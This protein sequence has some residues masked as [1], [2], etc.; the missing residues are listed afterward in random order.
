MGRAVTR[1]PEEFQQP[2]GEHLTELRKRLLR[3][4][5]AFAVTTALSLTLSAK[6]LEFLLRPVATTFFYGPAEA[7]SA[8]LRVAVLIGLPLGWPVLMYQLYAFARPGLYP[9]ER[10]ALALILPVGSLMFGLGLVFG[11]AVMVPTVLVWLRRFVVP[12]V[13]PAISVTLY[14][15]FVVNSILPFGFAFQLPLAVGVLSRLGV[16]TPRSLARSRR[17]VL[18][19]ILI[20]A[21]LLTP[22]D[23]V[24][25]LTMTLPMVVLYE[26]SILVARLMRLRTARSG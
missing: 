7:F 1:N 10:R 13:T 21:A 24:S 5:F 17:W 22:P 3:T 20:A 25:Q 15:R 4:L 19:A 14:T 26:L 8:H 11:Y 2:L 23:V 18:L 9:S 6:L 12:G 16:V